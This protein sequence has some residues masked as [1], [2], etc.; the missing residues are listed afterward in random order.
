MYTVKKKD[1][2]ITVTEILHSFRGDR[3]MTFHY[4]LSAGTRS[5]DGKHWWPADQ[6]ALD[7]AA[8]H[9]LPKAKEA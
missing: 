6:G 3:L 8:K 1:D 7:W 4:N 5:D 9:Y 2:V